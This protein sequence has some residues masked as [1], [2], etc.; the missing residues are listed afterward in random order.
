MHP[1]LQVAALAVFG[2]VAALAT[3]S[4]GLHAGLVVLV[5]TIPILRGRILLGLGALLVGFGASF[6][7]ALL[8]QAERGG[9]LAE[10]GFWTAVAVGPLV[11][12]GLLLAAAAARTVRRTRTADR[13]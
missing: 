4:F 6:G 7:F 9:Q 1:I 2:A 8:L 11:V 12:G 13:T 10:A 3:G 5:L